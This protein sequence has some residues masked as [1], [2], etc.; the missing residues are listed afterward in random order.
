MDWMQLAKLLALATGGIVIV[1]T[2]VVGTMVWFLNHPK[3]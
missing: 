3:D 2:L 1:A